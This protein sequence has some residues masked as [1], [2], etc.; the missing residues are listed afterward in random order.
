[1]SEPFDYRSVPKWQA[2]ARYAGAEAQANGRSMINGD[3]RLDIALAY[4]VEAWRD[5]PAEDRD[6]A[7]RLFWYGVAAERDASGN[8]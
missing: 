5:M 6:T 2:A 3:D 4:G 7:M 8:L 1:M